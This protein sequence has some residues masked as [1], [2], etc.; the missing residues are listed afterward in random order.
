MLQ[1]VDSGSCDLEC[2]VLRVS[3]QTHGEGGVLVSDP[4][5]DDRDGHAL[6]VHERRASVARSVELDR[7]H[8]TPDQHLA[9]KV[10]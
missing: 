4:R 3:I 9:P 8:P 1:V 5:G 2:F 6:E 7:P 10:G